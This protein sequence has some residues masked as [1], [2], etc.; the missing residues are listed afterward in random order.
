MS[1]L[2]RSI[3]MIGLSAAP[4]L[5]WALSCRGDSPRK[6]ADIFRV[7]RERETKIRAASFH[8]KQTERNKWRDL[9][10]LGGRQKGDDDAPQP[11]QSIEIVQQ[12]RVRLD[13]KRLDFQFDAVNAERFRSP[14][15]YRQTFD[16]ELSWQYSGVA[17]A[18]N[19]GSGDVARAAYEFSNSA[20][21][22]PLL[23]YCR[24][25]EIELRTIDL[26]KMTLSDQTHTIYSGGC[27]LLRGPKT[28]NLRT[29]Y[30]VDMSDACLIRRCEQTVDEQPRIRLDIYYGTDKELGWIPKHWRILVLGEDGATKEE[31]EADI[32]KYELHPKFAVD[33][34][35]ITFPKG[36]YVEDR[37]GVKMRR[38][39]V[40][41]R[42]FVP[43]SARK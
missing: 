38:A 4:L 23:M 32:E 36:T 3:L 40:D 16:G 29:Q 13:G 35:R 7:W 2:H 26:R 18:G 1:L 6:I 17:K 34:F 21:P 30:Y 31:T 12:C 43:E 15:G 41:E 19:H 37:T 33:D 22:W 8:W 9:K 28:S 25:F 14:I 27:Q 10:G 24:P 42:P 5:V 39:N 11:G 20:Y